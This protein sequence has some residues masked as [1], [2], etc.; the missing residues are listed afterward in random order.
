MPTRWATWAK[1]LQ[2]FHVTISNPKV[3]VTHIVLQG[4]MSHYYT[5]RRQEQI[6]L[7][8]ERKSFARILTWIP[9]ILR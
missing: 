4:N 1:L 2:K 5:K 3:L 7:Q 6:I 9:L 8:Q